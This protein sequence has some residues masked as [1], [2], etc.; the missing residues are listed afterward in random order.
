[1]KV[2]LRV[3]WGLANLVATWLII[4]SSMV[5]AQ[6]QQEHVH[7]MSHSVMPFEMTRTLHIFEMTE[8]GGVLQVIA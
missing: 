2:S 1:M 5:S 3:F 6:T 4:S 8:T 7:Q